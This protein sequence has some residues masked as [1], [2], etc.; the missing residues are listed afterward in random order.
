ML[1]CMQIAT[2]RKS[3][4]CVFAFFPLKANFYCN[5]Q[6]RSQQIWIV[7]AQ[8][9]TPG[10]LLQLPLPAA[11]VLWHWKQSNVYDALSIYYRIQDCWCDFVVRIWR[12]EICSTLWSEQL[13]QGI[14]MQMIGQLMV[15][16]DLVRIV[17]CQTDDLIPVLHMFLNADNIVSFSLLHFVDFKIDHD[18]STFKCVHIFVH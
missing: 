18:P 1:T 12:G 10:H 2:W 5:L 9:L 17:R 8:R 7:N 13:I 16:V 11:S 3:S 4:R 15:L 14:W 6:S